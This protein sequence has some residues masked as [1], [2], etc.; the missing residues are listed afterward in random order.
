MPDSTQ[1]GYCGQLYNFFY[2]TNHRSGSMKAGVCRVT[3]RLYLTQLV[4][5]SP[6]IATH[7]HI[8]KECLLKGFQEFFQRL[9]FL[10]FNFIPPWV[11][12]TKLVSF[13]G[14]SLTCLTAGILLLIPQGDVFKLCEIMGSS[15][16]VVLC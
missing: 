6:W 9:L 16:S 1:L 10:F 12:Q 3:A 5:R 2:S 4:R 11:R 7:N 13:R 15:G 8:T 14:I